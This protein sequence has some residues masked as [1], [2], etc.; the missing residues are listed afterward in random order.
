MLS[1]TVVISGQVT[2]IKCELVAM[3]V[4][5][6]VEGQRILG[7]L[8]TIRRIGVDICAAQGDLESLRD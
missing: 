7:I 5:K 6:P 8:Q 1:A 2:D 4:K 3:T